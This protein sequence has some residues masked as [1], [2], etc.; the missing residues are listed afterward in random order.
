[1]IENPA[2]ETRRGF[3]MDFREV[4]HRLA[5]RDERSIKQIIGYLA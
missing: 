1:M 3:F 4:E 5:A 2:V